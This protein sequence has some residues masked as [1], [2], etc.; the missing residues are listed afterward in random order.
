MATATS[1]GVTH[2]RNRLAKEKSPYLLQHASNPVDWY[3]WGEEAFSKAR[4]EDKPIFLSVG[5]STCHWCHVMERESF[6]SEEI[7]KQLNESF[8]SIKVDREER[9]DVDRVYMTFVQATQGGGGWPMSVFMTPDLKPFLAG[10]YFPPADKYG[11]PGFS[12]LLRTI[13]HQWKTSRHR[14]VEQ[15]T[16]IMDAI[17]KALE[18]GDSSGSDGVPAAGCVQKA[19]EMFNSRFD[20]EFGGFGDAP[21]FP[22]PA[23]LN[24]LLHLFARYPSSPM[25]ERA[26]EMVSFTLRAMANGGIHDHVGQGFHRYSTDGLWHVPHFEKMLYDQAQLAAAYA[27]AYQITRDSVFAEMTHDILLYVSRDLSDEDGGFYSAEDADSLS[28]EGAEHKKEGAFCVWSQQEINSLLPDATP[29]N[30]SKTWADVFSYH[31]GVKPQGNVD[32]HKDPH[33]ELKGQNVLIVRGSLEDTAQHFSLGVE[34]TRELLGKD[35]KILTAWNGLMITGFAKA[36]QALGDKFYL[37]CAVKAASFIKDHL[38]DEKKGVLVRNGYRDKDGT[39]GVGDVEGFADDYAFLIR[40]LLD[41]YEAGYDQQWLKLAVSLQDK[42]NELF[43]DEKKGGYFNS[44][45]LDPS[46]LLR[47]KEDQDGAEPNP[48]SVSVQNLWR[49]AALVDKQEYKEMSKKVMA[50][51]SGLLGEHPVVLPEMLCALINHYQS[52]KQI[53]LVGEKDSDD[54]NAMIRCVQHLYIPNKV[55]IVHHPGEH[56]YLTERLSVLCS[57]KMQ[58]RRATAYVCQNYVCTQ[59]ISDVGQ[60]AQV[61]DSRK[62]V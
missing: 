22:Q 61:L 17:S 49:L 15:S 41:L 32:P 2:G 21:K 31:Y 54:L 42:Q 30:P 45:S 34:E 39:L 4:S 52:P 29:T 38:Y 48:N 23:I 58:E 33:G 26:L 6:E 51:F 20:D 25:G 44:T 53:I 5:Y 19:Y 46:I 12:T 3:P 8:V 36:S 37:D 40:A 10:T 62:K 14:L 35:D 24:F 59:P 1:S 50:A 11:R 16:K 55:T 18:G 60:L 7:G 27:T 47:L 56:S 9:P 13:A 28:A 43:W 57:M